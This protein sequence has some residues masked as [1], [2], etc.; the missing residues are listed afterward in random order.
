M[1]QTPTHKSFRALLQAELARRTTTN[2]RYSVRGFAR[3]LHVDHATL[4]QWLRGKRPLTRRAI[5]QLGARLGLDDDAIAAFALLETSRAALAPDDP[6]QIAH[7]AELLTADGQHHAVLEAL[8][9]VPHELRAVA[10]LLDVEEEEL[11]VLLQ[12]LLRFGLLVLEGDRWRDVY[13]LGVVDVAAWR[14][15]VWDTAAARIAARKATPTKTTTPTT[16]PSTSPVQRFQILAKDVDACAA[17]YGSVF[18]WRFSSANAFGYREVD[19]GGVAGGLW[20]APPEGRGLVQLFVRVDD[21]SAAVARA[22]DHGAHVIVPPQVLPDGDEMA[23]LL[24]GEGL[25]VGVFRPRAL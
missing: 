18:G 22:K 11:Q 9:L 17:F 8:T 2:P 23:L 10:R 3:F 13:G 19:T 16:A 25:P 7:D 5:E 21:V 1:D 6:A 12:R 24:D 4:S 15:A 14:K 20:P